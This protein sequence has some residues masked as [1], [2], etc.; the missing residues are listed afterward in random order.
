MCIAMADVSYLPISRNELCH[1]TFS[2][3]R[4]LTQYGVA[5]VIAKTPLFWQSRSA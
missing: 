4:F 1:Y 3:S 2:L 5:V